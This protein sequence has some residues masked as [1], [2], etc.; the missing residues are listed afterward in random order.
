MACSYKINFVTLLNGSLGVCVCVC[1]CMFCVLLAKF[2]DYSQV[3]KGL[4]VLSSDTS[5]TSVVGKDGVIFTSI[6]R[7][8]CFVP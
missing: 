8:V 2:R 4:A 5:L 7:I 1:V 3:V 6:T